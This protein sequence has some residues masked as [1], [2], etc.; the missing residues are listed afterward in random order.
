MTSI[1]ESFAAFIA[2]LTRLGD[3]LEDEPTVEQGAFKFAEGSMLSVL[4]LPDEQHSYPGHMDCALVVS[5]FPP[6]EQL[7]V[8]QFVCNWKVLVVVRSLHMVAVAKRLYYNVKGRGQGYERGWIKGKEQMALGAGR[9]ER[10][11]SPYSVPY[12]REWA[13]TGE[14]SGGSGED[15]GKWSWS[16][17]AGFVVFRGERDGR[18]RK[19]VRERKVVSDPL[20]DEKVF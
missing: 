4:V 15:G 5:L 17:E 10:S 19:R 3:R 20:G 9:G 13:V 1:A 12:G 16:N 8:D 6:A 18:K 14:Q 7:N 11:P 2:T